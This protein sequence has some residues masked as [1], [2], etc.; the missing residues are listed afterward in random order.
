[1]NYN[2]CISIP[3]KFKSFRESKSVIEKVINS[4][5]NLIEFRF[6]YISNA[7]IISSDFLK[8]ILNF[9]HPYNIVI[10]TFRDVS[11]GGQSKLEPRERLKIINKFIDT[12]PNYIDIEMN[13]NEEILKEIIP[14]ASQKDIKL[15]FSHHSFEKPLTYNEV[16]TLIHQFQDMLIKHLSIYPKILK[17][18]IYKVVFTANTFED[19]L[20]ALR[21]CEK[22]SNSNLKIISFC[23]GILGLFS[24]I[25]CVT[26]GSFMTYASLEEE[27]AP[28]QINIHKMRELYN[29]ISD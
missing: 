26:K 2:I 18:S 14:L 19:N 9:I 16:K 29:L 28:G 8:E 12:K 27:T 17:E 22:Y 20:T 13:T 1:M 24:R 21:I 7:G 15:I 23:L 25:M 3:F 10:F 11:E 4:K 6:D 5:P